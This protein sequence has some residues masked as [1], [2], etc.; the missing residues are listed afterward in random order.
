MITIQQRRFL[1][2]KLKVTSW[3]VLSPFFDQL[4]SREINSKHDLE[5]WLKNRS[6]LEAFVSEDLAWRYVRMTCD[7]ENK[8]LEKAYLFFVTEIEPQIA[9]LSDKLNHKLVSSKYLNKLD[10]DKYF[11]YLRSVKKEIELFREEN[12]PL[13]AE[14]STESQKYGAI[15]GSL[16]VE[17]DGKEL[18]LQQASNYL[19]NPDRSKREEA[20]N[21]IQEKRMEKTP[22][23]DELFN[24]LVNL[25]H[26]VAVN[27]GFENFRDYMFAAMGRFDYTPQD[28]FAFHD[29]I[30][31]EVMSLVKQFTEKRQKELG[32]TLRPW[33]MEVDTKNR[34]ALEP[35]TSGKDL[36]DR[37]VKCFR[38]VDDYFA[39]CIETMDNMARLDLESRKGKAPG[40]YNYPMAE[41]GVPF[42]FM[43]AASS[44]RDVETMVHE[45]GHAVH[46]FLSKDLELAA[47]KSCPSEVA[48]LASMSMEL[49]SY[50]GQDEFYR[51]PEELN[52]AKEEHLEGIIKILPWIATID[53]FQHWIYTHPTHTAEERKVYW[54]Q[55]SKEFG[56]GM[57]DWSGYELA[58]AYTWQKQLHLY[59]VPFYYIEYGMAQLGALAV[60]RNFLSDKKRAVQQYKEALSLGYTKTIGEIYKTAGVE[61]NFSAPYIKELMKFVKAE[62]AKI[63]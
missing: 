59:E 46:S 2:N 49:I 16:S 62:L 54:V 38:K 58:Q 24:R 3:D 28:C 14:I 39:W 25:R 53:K 50:D 27:A 20:F 60:W 13:F 30:Q 48:E 33:D 41:T 52:R 37:T 4:L 12:V 56:T 34:E 18:T 26:K 29:A 57:V 51:T 55:L 9:P 6:E 44:T 43:N 22:E 40:G 10:H 7:T 1:P 23:L 45:G 19:K 8:E 11:I 36:L 31:Q 21:K 35:F 5:N 17:L 47:F 32:H 15:I 61:F 42:I 63:A